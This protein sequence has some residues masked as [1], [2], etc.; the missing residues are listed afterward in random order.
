MATK[1]V[2]IMT[3]TEFRK[4]Y[5]WLLRKYPDVKNV[6]GK[7]N[8]V[9]KKTEF[10]LQGDDWAV[11]STDD[12]RMWDFERYCNT[13]DAIPFFESLGGKEEVKAEVVKPFGWIP[14]SVVS[15]SPDGK[16]KIRWDVDFPGSIR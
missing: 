12:A 2:C 5:K 15:I 14:V 7:Y 9:F 13:F 11:V 8:F 16:K 10:E 1:E 3:Q 6:Y 4:T